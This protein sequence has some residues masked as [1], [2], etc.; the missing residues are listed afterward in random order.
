MKD[1]KPNCEQADGSSSKYH[2]FLKVRKRR[3]ERRK[4]KRNP[5]CVSTYGKYRGY[6]L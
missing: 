6:E 3:C 1:S 4:A 2:T 5:E